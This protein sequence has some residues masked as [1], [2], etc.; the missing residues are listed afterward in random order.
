M[1]VHK[2][3]A[4]SWLLSTTFIACVGLF[5][6]FSYIPDYLEI[7]TWISL[8]S[9]SFQGITG[10][11]MA[12]KYRSK[13]HIVQR[14]M[15][16]G[17][18]QLINV[19]V[20]TSFLSPFV[21]EVF[22]EY[23]IGN[24]LLIATAFPSIIFGLDEIAGMKKRFEVRRLRKHEEVSKQKDT[25]II[26]N[27]ASYGLMSLIGFFGAATSIIF[28]ADPSHDRT[29]MLNTASRGDFVGSN[30]IEENYYAT[31]LFNLSIG[32]GMFAITLRDKRLVSK[33]TEQVIII[34]F[35]SPL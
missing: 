33:I 26:G 3:S 14:G 18:F 5:N 10:Y 2:I 11:Y 19:A 21:P 31:I 13:E 7:P 23:T 32:F 28:L 16:N 34:F 4:V 22:N 12:V 15:M 9:S 27:L 35:P 25:G 29:W 1:D 17:S 20:T 30:F 6:E 24:G 8:I